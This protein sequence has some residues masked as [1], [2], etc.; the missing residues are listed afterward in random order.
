[1]YQTLL[2]SI[3]VQILDLN[4]TNKIILMSFFFFSSKKKDR[5]ILQKVASCDSPLIHLTGNPTS[6][7]KSQNPLD[8]KMKS[9]KKA[10]IVNRG[11][12]ENQF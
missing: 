2:Y 7:L 6:K 9:C 1:M 3:L 4:L 8:L 11:V 12:K 5:G 10:L